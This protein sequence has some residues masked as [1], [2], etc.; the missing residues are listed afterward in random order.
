MRASTDAGPGTRAS[1]TV[2]LHAGGQFRASEKSVVEAGLA[3]Q[4]GVV[5]VEA[6]PVAQT[7]TVRYDPAVTSVQELRAAVERCGYECA[8]CNVPGCLCDPLHEPAQA[9]HGHDVAAVA[10]ADD[11]AGHGEGGHGGHSMDQMAREMRNRFVVALV[12]TLA[13]LAWS[14]IGNSLFGH[15]LATPA[16]LDRNVWQL[17]L[18]LPVLFAARRFF[19]G[20]VAA[21]RQ[22]TLDMNV[23]IAAAIGT[24]W[25][26]SLAVT[27]GLSGQ[28]FYDAGAMLATFVLLGHWFEMRS[29]GSA[30]DAIR[31][32]LDLAPP[33]A[34][35]LR[36]GEPV[37]VLTAQVV[38]GDMLLIRPGAK[39]PVD[40]EV[41]DGD[42]EVDESAVTGESLPVHKGP[43]DKLVGATINK[44]GTLRARATAIGS[45]TALAQIVGLVQEAQ[46]SKAPA[47][48][49]ADRAASWLVVVALGAGGLTFAGWMLAGA[50]ARQALLYA[51]T[52]VVIT[53]PDALGLATPTAIMVG[54]GLGAKRGILF[55]NAA[56]LED[57]ASLDTVVFDKT[58]TLTLGQPEVVE[59]VTAD[60]IEDEELLRMVAAA[61][62][63]SEHP[64][65]QAIVN[66]ARAR[67]LELPPSAGFEA[68]PGEG[69]LTTVEGRRVAVGN[70][71]LLE[72][73]HVSLDGLAERA[74][75]LAGQ[76]R[77][78][79][80]VGLDGRAA[81][82][83]AIAD[84][85][86]PTSKEAVA[87]L[88]QIGIHAVMLTGDSR[89]TAERVAAQ[90]GIEDVIAEVLPGDKAAMI[91]ELQGQ[92][93]KVAMV[94]DGVNDAPA[95]AQAHVGIAIGTGTDVA[96]E[97]ADVV[98][99][100]SDP[101]DVATAI[102]ISRGTRRKERQ[103]LGWATGY[104]SLAIPI[105]A[106]ALQPAGFSLS[107]EIA[108]L[109]M[110]GSSI[111]VA[112]NAILLR[113]LHLP[114]QPR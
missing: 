7:A 67:N 114:D 17:L 104:N 83:I 88:R 48:R 49:L 16:G 10:R 44:N 21:L 94:G 103:N 65:A 96:V 40:A 18:S 80:Q 110:S 64:L 99:M 74:T 2:V 71:R 79:V 36:D 22:R 34:V 41:A 63:D 28:V 86:R 37:E 24:S 45:D 9:E 26:Y 53:C 91:A 111:I 50:D 102:T 35:V 20:A 46:N 56:A 106:G 14:S 84:A 12:F 87:A 23:L 76:G 30:S 81:G 58:G 112:L 66:A 101:L 78:T 11:P 39:V 59:I 47:Q 32:L 68:I 95:L 72:R 5:S 13:I 82:V 33:K 55:K 113:R 3:R 38:V 85:P 8:G 19:T 105:A 98:L 1:E 27:A 42:S 4:P 109:L 54:S 97:T 75:Q 70:V 90:I 77:T 51:I 62:L 25:V 100:R 69:A 61:E 73:E 60:G 92:G 52:V 107:P 93:R 57:I 6:N 31:T 43:G 89:A 29:R 15:Y 108:A